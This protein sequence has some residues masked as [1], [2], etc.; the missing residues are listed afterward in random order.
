LS[1]K[2]ASAD[3]VVGIKVAAVND[4]TLVR[5]AIAHLKNARAP[6]NDGELMN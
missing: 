5:G 1:A 6:R 4:S 3:S 2:R